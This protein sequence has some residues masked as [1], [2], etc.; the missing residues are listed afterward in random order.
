MKHVFFGVSLALIMLVLGTNT[1][2]A[3]LPDPVRISVVPKYH[4]PYSTAYV[5][6]ESFILDLN[7]ATINWYVNG[8]L[9]SDARNETQFAYTLGDI[10]EQVS[11]TAQV[12]PTTG[13]S[14]NASVSLTPASVGLIWEG[15]TYTPPF[16][17]GRS[18]FTSQS[19]L[20]VLAVP[21]IVVGGRQVPD[22]QLIFTWEQDETILGS[23]SG[24]GKNSLAVT[25][26]VL[27]QPEDIAVT[28]STLDGTVTARTSITVPVANSIVHVYENNPLRGVVFGT[29]FTET[30]TVSDDE[31][32][33]RGYPYF[34]PITNPRLLSWQWQVG[35]QTTADTDITLRTTTDI[36]GTIPVALSVDDPDRLL[37]SAGRSFSVVFE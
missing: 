10:G 33:L 13:G 22:D 37:Q 17:K 11:I 21:T 19:T 23:K 34:F 14:T 20:R 30:H 25:G 7:T 9:Q 1:L 3:Q 4:A 28:V 35:S 2:Y 8:T 29:A 16:Y 12:Q 24:R 31:I 18:L 36:S 26:S 32:T 15:D 27:S 5:T 6:I